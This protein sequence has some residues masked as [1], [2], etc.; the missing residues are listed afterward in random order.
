MQNTNCYE[1][2]LSTIAT[3]L[4]LIR[5]AR[6]ISQSDLSSKTG[7]SR[8]HIIN[9]ETGR[10]CPSIQTLLVISTA[11]N[12]PITQLFVSRRNI[13]YENYKGSIISH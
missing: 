1:Q 9:L 6:N 3:N 13:Y 8:S 2:L 5:E 12:V 7:F 11:L 10:R 4:V